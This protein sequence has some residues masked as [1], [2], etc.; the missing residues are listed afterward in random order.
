MFSSKVSALIKC[1]WCSLTTLLLTD[2]TS[3]TK[4][5]D[6]TKMTFSNTIQ[7]KMIKISIA[8]RTKEVI[9]NEFFKLNIA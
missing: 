2:L 8:S 9:K 6:L 7:L 4:I 5:S 1:F 3:R